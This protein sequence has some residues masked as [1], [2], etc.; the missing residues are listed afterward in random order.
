M[1]EIGARKCLVTGATGVVGVPLVQEL[2]RRGHSVRVLT[3]SEIEPD[4]FGPPV[5]IACGDLSDV[6]A[7]SS[8]AKS[9]DWIFHL[10]AKLHV[11]DP[12][13]N[14]LEEYRSVNVEGTRNLLTA[15]VENGVKKII[16]FSTIN[17][18]GPGRRE[19]TF[20]ETSEPNPIGIYAESKRTAE[21]I[22]LAAVNENGEKPGIV[23]RLAAVYGSRMKGNYVRLVEAVS[24]GRFVLI[25]SGKNRRTLVHQAD[26]ARAAVLAAEH[27]AGGSVYNVTDGSIHTLKDIVA[28]IG[29]AAGKK[30]FR[31]SL[32]EMPIRIGVAAVEK[33]ARTIGIRLPVSTSLLEKFLEDVAVDGGKIHSE[34][35]FRPEFDLAAGWRE[36][37]HGRRDPSNF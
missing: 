7:I 20:D 2:L 14:A 9:I 28:A 29:E 34:L 31:L 5:E 11:N 16:F 36:T 33:L 37:L 13:E 18:Y 10:A 32:P 17:V 35:G 24:R 3:R 30:G 26:V 25:G 15:S 19:Q 4:F 12:G 21:E 1:E 6:S 27:A 8:A 22:V 23:L